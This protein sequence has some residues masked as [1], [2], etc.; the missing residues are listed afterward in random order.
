MAKVVAENFTVIDTFSV[1]YMPDMLGINMPFIRRYE[2][3][4][5]EDYVPPVPPTPPPAKNT[6]VVE[7]ENAP[8][9]LG[10]WPVLQKEAPAPIIKRQ[11]GPVLL[12][13]PLQETVGDDALGGRM[14]D[15]PE[16]LHEEIL[17]KAKD[18]EIPTTTVEHRK[19]YMRSRP[20]FYGPQEFKQAVKFGYLHP[21]IAAPKGLKWKELAMGW[22]L[23]PVEGAPQSQLVPAG[24]LEELL[25]T[26]QPSWSTEEVAAEVEKLAKI[27]IY[28]T[29]D[30]GLWLRK[31]SAESLN[32]RLE[33]AS[34]EHLRPEAMQAISQLAEAME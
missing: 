18:H 26:R 19:G 15:V 29:A 21:R 9:P 13:E 7:K 12:R 5:G 10:N 27:R 31:R 3:R 17:A 14:L 1:F 6:P 16:E 2:G 30:L 24:T 8:G 32:G 34:Q 23:V 20:T 28:S 25:R 22:K 11:P 4:P 33:L